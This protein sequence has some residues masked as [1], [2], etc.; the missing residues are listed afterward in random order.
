MKKTIL[1]AILLLATNQ[2]FAQMVLETLV[3][4]EQAHYINYFDKDLDSSG[5]WNFF[6][7]NRF[8]VNYN[9]KTLNAVSI[10]GQLSYQIKP[11]LGISTGGGFYGALFVPTIGLSLSYL[12]KKE[13]FFIQMYPT[14]GLAEGQIAPSALGIIGYAPK[15]NKSWGL[16]SQIIFSVDPIEASQIVRM[17]VSYKDKFQFGIGIDMMQNFESKNF[18]FNTGPFIRINF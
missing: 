16:S 17:G 15:F 9:D 18:N 13:D 2:L 4:N 3:G 6:N 5:K 11:W 8:T 7:L 10:E 14:V 12:N 1:I